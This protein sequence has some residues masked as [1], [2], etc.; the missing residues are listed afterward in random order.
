MSISRVL[1][2]KDRSHRFFFNPKFL[3][4]L[5]L[6]VFWRFFF[7]FQ[8]FLSFCFQNCERFITA[9][10]DF[11]GCCENPQIVA[12]RLQ[13]LDTESKKSVKSGKY[14]SPVR[15]ALKVLLDFSESVT[16]TFFL[17]QPTVEKVAAMKYAASNISHP[18]A[19]HSD[20]H[21]RS[22]YTAKAIDARCLRTEGGRDVL[23][24]L[25]ACTKCAVFNG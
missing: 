24:N 23:N 22:R 9:S 6:F 19:Q 3:E 4:F 11:S 15:T 21:A 2:R 16:R 8:T 18:S 14:V 5:V 1:T 12:E 20:R 25:S 13:C 17:W 10:R 7:F